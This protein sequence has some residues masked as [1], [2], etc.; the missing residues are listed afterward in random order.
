MAEVEL[1]TGLEELSAENGDGSEKGR[2][3]QWNG[4]SMILMG[5]KMTKLQGG[6]GVEMCWSFAASQVVL[7]IT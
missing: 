7:R 1:Q 4:Y 3:P 5:E 6:G 2:M